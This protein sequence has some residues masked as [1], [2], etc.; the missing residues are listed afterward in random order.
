VSGGPDS[1]AL[2][3]LAQDWAAARGGHVIALVLDHG[4]RPAAATEAALAAAWLA[5][6][7]IAVRR[8][9]LAATGARSAEA[10]R[11]E[12]IAALAEA[13]AAAG[14]LHLLLAHHRGD[15][16][17]TV[18]VRAQRGSRP[19]GLA[20]MAP[21]RP[22]GPVRL[23]RPLL[24]CGAGALRAV[25]RAAGQPWIEDPSNAALTV[26]ARLRAALADRAG[27]GAGV[28]ALADLASAAAASRAAAEAR[29][30][31][32]LAEAVTLLPQGCAR[33]DAA[34]LAE[35][36]AAAG[37][38]VLAALLRAV[39]GHAHPVRE[40]RLVGL[41]ASLRAGR[42]ATAA[43]CLLRPGRGFWLLCREPAAVAPPADLPA[44]GRLVWDGRWHVEA[45]PGLT[46]GAVG[47]EAA[48]LARADRHAAAL[49]WAVLATLP[50][51]RDGAA[52]VAVPPIGYHAGHRG[53]T[54]R[55]VFRP[56]QPVS[57]AATDRVVAAG[58]A[59]L[60]PGGA[61]PS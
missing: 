55:A 39:G 6:R 53:G 26:R 1:L 19:A 22:A 54:M 10:L 4:V 16:A 43:G 49:P 25:L 35:A 34:R 21:S 37:A 47:G 5:A 9:T 48:A 23:V 15:Q 3:L 60:A 58:A 44:A 27:E 14:C 57:A 59:A 31:R 52:L 50:G 13:A 11:R 45:P 8:L 12:R 24:G 42:A 36:A 61:I 33:I 18:L 56:P 7:G 40:A 17:E 32:L 2:A 38:A 20:A 30:D 29:R 46:V 41:I 51:L 28:R